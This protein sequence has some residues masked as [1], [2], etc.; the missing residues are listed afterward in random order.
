M[1]DSNAPTPVE[2]VVESSSGD[3]ETVTLADQGGGVYIASILTATGP[4]GADGVLQTALG[5]TIT[6]TYTDV[7]DGNGNSSDRI[8]TANI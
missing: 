2:A 5:D 1:S 8:V 6:V 4:N 7:D 3:I